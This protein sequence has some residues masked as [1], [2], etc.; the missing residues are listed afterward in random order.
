MLPQCWRW[1]L[2]HNIVAI[3]PQHWYNLKIA[4][5]ME[6]YIIS[7]CCH[8]VGTTLTTTLYHNVQARLCECGVPHW[9][10]TKLQYS[11]NVELLCNFHHCHNVVIML[12]EHCVNIVS[13]AKYQCP[14]N[15]VN[16]EITSFSML[17]QHWRNTPRIRNLISYFENEIQN[18]QI[19]LISRSNNIIL[20]SE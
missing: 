16:W 17:Q 14:H 5:R 9:N 10:L 4:T 12:P 3:L 6:N 18:D 7:W 11:G 1:M 8:N 20:W 19:I 13:R 2:Y 15:I